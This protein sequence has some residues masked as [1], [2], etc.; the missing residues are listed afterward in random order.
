MRL[1]RLSVGAFV[2]AFVAVGV[3]APALRFLY[4]AWR[5]GGL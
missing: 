2:L 1:V 3:V 4:A 5:H